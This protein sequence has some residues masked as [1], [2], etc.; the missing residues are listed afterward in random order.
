MDKL[1]LKISVLVISIIILIAVIIPAALYRLDVDTLT[2]I[3]YK[4]A[5]GFGFQPGLVLITYDN[6]T[7]TID[8][9]NCEWE[10]NFVDMI[11]P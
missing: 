7:H 8:M 1:F 10:P 3:T 5:T 9:S 2:Q 11:S 4:C 6:G